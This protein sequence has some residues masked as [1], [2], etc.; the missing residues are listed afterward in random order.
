MGK[1]VRRREID[2]PTFHLLGKSRVGHDGD[3]PL[4]FGAQVFHKVEHSLGTHPTIRPQD[5]GV[6]LHGVE[7]GGG[8]RPEECPPLFGKGQLADDGGGVKVAGGS[9]RGLG[10]LQIDEGLHQDG[11][12]SPLEKTRDGLGEEGVGLVTV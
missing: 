8:R 10:L 6:T 2:N 12:G 5:Q 4:G 1:I 9:D 11:I 7:K 3:R